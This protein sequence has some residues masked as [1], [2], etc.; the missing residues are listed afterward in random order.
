[1]TSPA[2]PIPLHDRSRD[3]DAAAQENA[4]LRL[5]VVALEAELAA[6]RR[7]TRPHRQLEDLYRSVFD[8]L[9]DSVS[10][11]CEGVIVYANA[12][13]AHMLDAD[14]PDEIVGQ[15][16]REFVHPDCREEAKARGQR[17]LLEQV[18]LPLQLSRRRTIKGRELTVESMLAPLQW[19]G[20]PA[21]LT[22]T[23]DIS[24]RLAAE[25]K[26]AQAQAMLEEAINLT[27]DGFAMF[28]AEDRLVLFNEKYRE[29]LPTPKDSVKL[30]AT[31]EEIM[32]KIA[33]SDHVSQR[34]T[35]ERIE[36]GLRRRM[37]YHRNPVGAYEYRSPNGSWSCRFR[38]R[39]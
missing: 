5:R 37:E 10:V 9:P 24:A 34:T 31:F 15:Y 7:A 29:A 39:T 2:T 1:M 4:A 13:A 33:E 3:N 14:S 36:A 12:Q 28:D 17:V 26:A 25:A 11:H 22:L 32:R 27:T 23:R 19:E 18:V 6:A 30:G 21:F 20:R 8:V 35:P 16:A 38:S